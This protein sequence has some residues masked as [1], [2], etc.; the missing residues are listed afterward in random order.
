[1]IKYL[2]VINGNTIKNCV[3]SG[4]ILFVQ[5]YNYLSG[6][7]S[8]IEM[9]ESSFFPVTFSIF[10]PVPELSEP[11]QPVDEDNVRYTKRNIAGKDN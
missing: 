4:N 10:I 6:F 1:M 3:K 11:V 9:T 8:F 7:G 5:M 2:C